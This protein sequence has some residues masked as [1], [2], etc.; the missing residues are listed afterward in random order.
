[1]CKRIKSCFWHK[2]ATVCS[3]FVCDSLP[4]TFAW[5][6][7]SFEWEEIECSWIY[8]H[9]FMWKSKTCSNFEWCGGC[10]NGVGWSWTTWFL[11]FAWKR[12]AWNK[13]GGAKFGPFLI[14]V[15]TE[16]TEFWVENS[17][18]INCRDVTSIREGR[19]ISWI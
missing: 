19:V 13:C 15:V 12:G 7:Q 8:F 16:I 11:D 3:L 2:T 18:K 5:I 9:T 10:N 17:K 14:N 1:M 6:S 4:N